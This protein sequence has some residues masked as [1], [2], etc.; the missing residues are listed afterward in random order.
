[1]DV[2]STVLRTVLRTVLKTV[3]KTV[4]RTSGQY[5]LLVLSGSSVVYFPETGQA[6]VWLLAVLW[7]IRSH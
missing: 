2:I 5:L 6:V 3:L 4:L 7:G 1:M